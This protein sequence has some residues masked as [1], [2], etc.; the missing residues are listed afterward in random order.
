[1]KTY[2]FYFILTAVLL[3]ISVGVRAF[4]SLGMGEYLKDGNNTLPRQGD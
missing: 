3:L 1:M 2:L 4:V